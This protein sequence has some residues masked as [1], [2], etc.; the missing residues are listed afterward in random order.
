MSS[1][2]VIIAGYGIHGHGKEAVELFEKMRGLKPDGFTF[3]GVLMACS[4]AGLVEDGLRYF[5]Q[6]QPLYEIEP[7]LEHY[8]CV[9][10]EIGRVGRFNGALKLINEMPMEPDVG[11]RSSLLSS[12]RK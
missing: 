1:G 7:N 4:H 3:V 8:A 12:C 10:A 9:G 2:T 6:M 11:T 5:K